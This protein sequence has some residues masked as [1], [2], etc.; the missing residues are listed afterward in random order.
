[1]TIFSTITMLAC[2]VP[3]WGGL[4]AYMAKLIKLSEVAEA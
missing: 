1:M 3:I 2:I 4:I